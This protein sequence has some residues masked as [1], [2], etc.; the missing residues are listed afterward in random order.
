[1]WVDRHGIDKLDTPEEDSAARQGWPDETGRGWTPP[2]DILGID[3]PDYWGKPT[4]T[5]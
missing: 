2:W 3:P 5:G 4:K 1:G